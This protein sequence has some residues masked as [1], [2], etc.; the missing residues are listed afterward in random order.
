MVTHCYRKSISDTL[1]K[2]LHF[3]NFLQNDPLDE[4]TKNEMVETRDYLLQDIFDKI[5]INMDNEYL[6]SIYFF[7]TGLFD[8]N[9][10]NEEKDIFTEVVDNKRIMRALIT[11]TFHDLDLIN[12]NDIVSMDLNK[13]VLRIEIRFAGFL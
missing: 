13:I 5:D 9:N 1:S 2:L 7:I 12:Y 8:P 4:E 3:E 6:N 10:I 11:K